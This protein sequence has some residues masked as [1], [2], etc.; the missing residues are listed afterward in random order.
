[1][2]SGKGCS[3]LLLWI[4]G[5]VFISIWVLVIFVGFVGISDDSVPP[6]VAPSPTHTPRVATVT[7]EE[8]ETRAVRVA[9][10]RAKEAEIRRQ[11]TIRSAT[12][13][14]RNSRPEYKT[15]VAVNKTAVA[16]EAV[17]LTAEA[18]VRAT[19]QAPRV[20]VEHPLAVEFGCQWILDTYR[21]MIQLGRDW[22]VL[23][24]SNAMTL[25][26]VQDVGI[27]RYVTSG[28]AAEALRECEDAG[29]R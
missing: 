20:E 13:T 25:K 10:N 6:T 24:L 14:A 23:H 16:V 9:T 19:V 26:Y 28:D 15:A 21:P 1:M 7:K 3:R 12:G 11:G 17:D 22:A 2:V 5:G 8:A 4:A 18:I 29:Y 27:N